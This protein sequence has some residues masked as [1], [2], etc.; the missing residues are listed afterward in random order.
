MI[1]HVSLP[2][3]TSVDVSV[4]IVLHHNGYCPWPCSELCPPSIQN[5]SDTLTSA[6]LAATMNSTL[7]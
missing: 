6:L 7:L 4:D 1:K 5:E 3:M 2:L